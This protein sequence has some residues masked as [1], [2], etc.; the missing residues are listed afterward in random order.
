VN[1]FED[2]LTDKSSGSGTILKKVQKQLLYLGETSGETDKGIL[3]SSLQVLQEHFP[4]FG[5][6]LHFNAAVF[7]H[8]RQVDIIS[9]KQLSR[10]VE[11]YQKTWKD[12]QDNSSKQ[13]IEGISVEGKN[14]LLHSNSSALHNLFQHLAKANIRPVVWQTYSSPG[15]EGAIQAEILSN[16]GFMVNLIHEDTVGRFIQNFDMAILGADMILDDLFLNKAGSFPITLT[17]DHFNKPV[18]LL[19]EE[20][21]L[22]KK[23]HIPEA[24]LNN[25]L[26]EKPKPAR[27]LYRGDASGIRVHNYY[28]EWIPLKWINKVFLGE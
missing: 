11:N 1:L 26:N 28:F 8:F 17:F 16:S 6:L 19:A 22:F 2:I 10:F 3:F 24:V 18:Y 20:R 27:D 15:G 12:A 13:L 25:I 23:E 4:Q 9:G 5:L 21:K 14:I 7:K